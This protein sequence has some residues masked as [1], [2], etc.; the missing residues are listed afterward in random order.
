MFAD[1]EDMS[2]CDVLLHGSVHIVFASAQSRL[3]A[4]CFDVFLLE[5]VNQHHFER[6]FRIPLQSKESLASELASFYAVFVAMRL[7]LPFEEQR[8]PI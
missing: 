8:F 5:F 3:I 1:L 7:H 4:Y 2:Q 6:L